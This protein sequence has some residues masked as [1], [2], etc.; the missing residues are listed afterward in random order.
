MSADIRPNLDPATM[1]ADQLA[2]LED[3]IGV[4]ERDLAELRQIRDQARAAQRG[5][6]P[7]EHR[8]AVFLSRFT[9]TSSALIC[10]RFDPEHR[11]PSAL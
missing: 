9:L 1:T 11:P 2:N 3:V 8:S 7:E 6:L 10:D 4:M 5:G